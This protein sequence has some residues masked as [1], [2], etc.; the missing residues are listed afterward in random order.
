MPKVN[1][2]EVDSISE[3]APLPSGEY[4][5][6]LAA[7]EMDFTRA[8]DEMWRLRWQVKEGD[9][10]GRLL[11]DNLVFSQRAMPRAKLICASCGL[12]VTGE[13]ELTPEMLMDR[14]VMI[15]TIV[16]ELEDDHGVNKVRNEIP[17]DGYRSVPR[18]GDAHP[19]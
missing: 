11:F 7:V 15:T 17:W 12:D 5:C 14:N 4:R 3:F 2:P 6:A 19:F 18:T 1:F 16:E 9:Y 13:V 8:G 10:T